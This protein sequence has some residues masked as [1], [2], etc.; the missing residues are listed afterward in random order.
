[1]PQTERPSLTVVV[2]TYREAENLPEFLDRMAAVRAAHSLQLDML[3]MDDD[4]GDG[5]AEIIAARGMPWVN[6]VVRTSDRGL[7]QAVLEGLFLAKG[8]VLACMDAD[9]SHPPES[10]PEMMRALETGADFVIGSRYVAGGSTSDDWTALR[11][12][13]SQ[14]ATL[15]ARPLTSVRDPMAGFFVLRRSTFEQGRDFYPIGYKIGLELIV[16]CD[17]QHVVE[18]P[19]HFGNRRHGKS[20]LTLKQQI[21]YLE[22]LRRLYMYRCGI[23]P[24]S[25]AITGKTSGPPR[26]STR[27]PKGPDSKSLAGQRLLQDFSPRATPDD[28]AANRLGRDR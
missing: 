2:P 4:S 10:L 15:L 3:I 18:V 20:K 22:H 21:L 16:R 11:W 17:C 6:L 23:V 26:S 14:A 27:T 1:V 7:S 13:N 12:I 8:E 19:I 24:F 9:L 28:R 25:S 5:S